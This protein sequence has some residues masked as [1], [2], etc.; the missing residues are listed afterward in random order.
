MLVVLSGGMRDGRIY[1]VDAHAPSV[2]FDNGPARSAERYVRS[3]PEESNSTA[4]GAAI[5]FRLVVDEDPEV[6]SPLVDLAG[7]T[8]RIV[9]GSENPR[10]PGIPSL[11]G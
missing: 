6:R 9:S 5:V 10:G 11:L 4:L 3:Q 7:D 2:D 8:G 1:Y